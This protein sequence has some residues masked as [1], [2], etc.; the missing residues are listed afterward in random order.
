MKK[1]N[2]M[3][4]LMLLMT[5]FAIAAELGENQKGDCLD[6]VQTS[7]AAASIAEEI[8][9]ARLEDAEIEVEVISE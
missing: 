4:M 9:E 1:L 5:N 8:E 7:R 3:L 2:L 6:G